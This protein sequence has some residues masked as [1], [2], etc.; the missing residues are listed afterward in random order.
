MANQYPKTGVC[1]VITHVGEDGHILEPSE[2]ISQFCNACGAL[3][4]DKLNLAICFWSRKLS[5]FEAKKQDLWDKWLMASF[6]LP[7]GKH[8]LVKQNA[9]KIMGNAFQRWRWDLN[10]RFI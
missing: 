5:V 4:R 6:R 7:D 2:Y 8:E 1:Y 9:Y 3:V 10:K